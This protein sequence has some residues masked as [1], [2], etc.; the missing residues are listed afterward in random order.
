MLPPLVLREL[1]LGRVFT[2]VYIGFRIRHRSAWTT[3]RPPSFQG[4]PR[5]LIHSDLLGS[6]C[7]DADLAVLTVTSAMIKLQHGEE[8]H[9]CILGWPLPLGQHVYIEPVGFCDDAEN[10]SW[11]TLPT[12]V[13]SPALARSSMTRVPGGVTDLWAFFVEQNTVRRVH[14]R[15]RR[16]LLVPNG[17]RLQPGV[18]VGGLKE[19]EDG[20][21]M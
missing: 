4:E 13:V 21:P 15:P 19:R 8:G 17:K 12:V 6:R 16:Y 10:N 14:K 3:D 2:Q 18:T 1:L 20:H 7:N 11:L 5:M 9:V